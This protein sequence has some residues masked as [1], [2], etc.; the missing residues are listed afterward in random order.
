MVV[1]KKAEPVKP[2]EMN[3]G[4]AVVGDWPALSSAPGGALCECGRPVAE[5]QTFVCKD[6]I[7]SK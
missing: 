2:G 1:K 7:R 5:G 6:H 4:E 3:L